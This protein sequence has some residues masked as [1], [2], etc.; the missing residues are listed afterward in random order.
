MD[1]ESLNCPRPPQVA[2]RDTP[3]ACLHPTFTLL[4]H[5]SIFTLAVPRLVFVVHHASS[6]PMG[7]A[8]TRS[9]SSSVPSVHTC[10][11]P[12]CKVC[13]AVAHPPQV[14]SIAAFI[15]CQPTPVRRF[16]T[17]VY[18]HRMLSRG[19]SLCH[20]SATL[21]FPIQWHSSSFDIHFPL[22]IIRQL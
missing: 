16:G 6:H 22:I 1:I 3:G 13:S 17:L 19:V 2:I 8:H 14:F 21:G 15:C 9:S 20:S 12:I 7:P 11:T 10:H 4:A 18:A 5:C